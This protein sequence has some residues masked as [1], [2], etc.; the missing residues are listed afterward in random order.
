VVVG[1]VDLSLMIRPER[2]QGSDQVPGRFIWSRKDSV[3][4]KSVFSMVSK[5][6]KKR[7]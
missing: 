4:I 3:E 1:E 6:E 2:Q 5:K 7:V